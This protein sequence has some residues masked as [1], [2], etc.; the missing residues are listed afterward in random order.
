MV[1]YRHAP[2]VSAVS[3]AK[4]TDPSFETSGVIKSI[5]HLFK[6]EFVSHWVKRLVGVVML[7]ITTLFVATWNKMSRYIDLLENFE[8]KVSEVVK[9]EIYRTKN[10]GSG[11]LGRLGMHLADNA[12]HIYENTVGIFSSE[13]YR[14]KWGICDTDVK[15]LGELL[16]PVYHDRRMPF[17]HQFIVG[18]HAIG[19]AGEI[20]FL[21]IRA[22]FGKPDPERFLEN[23]G[24]GDS[25]RREGAHQHVYHKG[26]HQDAYK[27]VTEQVTRYLKTA[28]V[29]VAQPLM[30]SG[31]FFIDL[32]G[33]N[34]PWV[35]SMNIDCKQP[36]QAQGFEREADIYVVFIVRRPL[37]LPKAFVELLAAQ[38]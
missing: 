27:D 29:P 11:S 31:R 25:I 22:E 8:K 15:L 4:P 9:D 7:S 13:R 35:Q 19:Q 37:V 6:S 23:T 16:I 10:D 24:G 20:P 3:N 2:E 32:K 14:V 17:Q 30:L 18:Y 34:L 12:H 5:V 36:A 38:Q 1:V 33:T 28:S 26:T 21:S